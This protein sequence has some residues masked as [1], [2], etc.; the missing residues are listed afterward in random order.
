[1]TTFGI[2]VGIHLKYG[3]LTKRTLAKTTLFEMCCLH[4]NLLRDILTYILYDEN[5]ETNK[6][7]KKFIEKHMKNSVKVQ[8]LSSFRQKY[9]VPKISIVHLHT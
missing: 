6:H 4:V 8:T 7:T 3:P 1:M 2:A 5:K 9:W